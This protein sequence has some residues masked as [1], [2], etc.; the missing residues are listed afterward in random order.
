MQNLTDRMIN[1]LFIT[2]RNIVIKRRATIEELLK[3]SHVKRAQLY[4]HL[5]ILK[6]AKFIKT[7]RYE[8]KT[9]VVVT[10]Y[11]ADKNEFA[12]KLRGSKLFDNIYEVAFYVKDKIKEYELEADLFGTAKIHEAIVEHNRMTEDINIV[13]TRRHYKYL[14]LL[15]RSLRFSYNGPSK[16]LYADH[17]YLVPSLRAEILVLINGVKHPIHKDRRFYNLAPVLEARKSI[18]LEHAVAGK[19]L[20]VPK[21]RRKV[22]GQDVADALAFG[23]DVRKIVDILNKVLEEYPEFKEIVARNI[24][25]VEEYLKYYSE[26]DPHSVHQ[27]RFYLKYILE[28]VNIPKQLKSKISIFP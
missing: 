24:Q 26:L 4:K 18:T 13:V 7:F 15:L 23:A 12:E 11:V 16:L 8:R 19:F 6:A 2:Y 5:Q 17:T 22:D 21:M 28:K 25:E 3:D 20:A 10:E 1:S 27:V 9:Y 14:D